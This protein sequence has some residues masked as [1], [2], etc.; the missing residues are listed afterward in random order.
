MRSREII[1]SGLKYIH[2]TVYYEGFYEG[3]NKVK[4]EFLV[5]CPRI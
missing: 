2:T 5:L 1:S 3:T 4:Y